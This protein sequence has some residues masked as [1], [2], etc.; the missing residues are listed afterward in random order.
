MLAKW[1]SLSEICGEASEG[2]ATAASG[3][4][5]NLQVPGH[6]FCGAYGQAVCRIHRKCVGP[7][8]DSLRRVGV[9]LVN[10]FAKTIAAIT[11]SQQNNL[12]SIEAR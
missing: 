11:K 3:K 10:F 2:F 12:R 8:Q 4:R 7:R 1:L 6:V 9:G 5:Y